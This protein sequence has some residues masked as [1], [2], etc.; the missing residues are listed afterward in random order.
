MKK[1]I[2]QRGL[3]LS[4]GGAKGFAHL[5]AIKALEEKGFKPDIISGTSAGAIVAA[6]YASGKTPEAIVKLFQKKEFKNF[7]KLTLPRSGFFS[8]DKFKQFIA[9]H[10]AIETFEELEIPIH[11]VATNLDKGVSTT[12]STGPI[13]EPLMASCSIPILFSPVDIEGNHY[14][15]GGVFRN[16]P[17]TTI[18]PLCDTVIGVNVSPVIPTEYKQNLAHIVERTYHYLFLG[19]T[20]HDKKQCDLLIQMAKVKQFST[21]DLENIQ[22]IFDIGYE[23]TLEAWNKNKIDAKLLSKKIS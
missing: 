16:F 8:M 6:L 9:K 2:Y 4:G 14:V 15:D 19:N 7:A 17:V 3:A 22:E 20:L 13:L 23:T 12:F 11:V 10:L 1:R 18:R 21:F 5:G